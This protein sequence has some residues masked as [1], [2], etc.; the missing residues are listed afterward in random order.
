MIDV[1]GNVLRFFEID[2][3]LVSLVNLL[4]TITTT[5]AIFNLQFTKKLFGDPLG[6]LHR[7][8]KP[9]SRNRGSTSNGRG[10]AWRGEKRRRME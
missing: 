1:Q 4:E 6:E 7:S 9:P 3:V 10:R 2:H 5:G 8:P